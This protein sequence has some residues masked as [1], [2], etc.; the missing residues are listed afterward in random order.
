[1]DELS[2][3]YGTVYDNPGVDCSISIEPIDIGYTVSTTVT[4]T[5]SEDCDADCDDGANGGIPPPTDPNGNPLPPPAPL[6]PGKGG[7]PNQ[8]VPI[9]GSPARPTKWKP[10]YPV[11]NPKGGQPGASWDPSGHFDTDDGNGNRN[12]TSPNGNP[13]D[14]NNNPILG[15]GPNAPGIARII[16]LIGE[17]LWPI[18]VF[19]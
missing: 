11:N 2:N 14:H 3:D 7:Q 12:R 17:W 6:P 4:A 10:K 18:L 19:P 8:W 16:I 1:M 9:P 13:V 15:P 5:D